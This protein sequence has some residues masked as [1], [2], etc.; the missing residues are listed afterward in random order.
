MRGVCKKKALT[1]KICLKGVVRSSAVC[2]QKCSDDDDGDGDAD[3]MISKFTFFNLK[4]LKTGNKS[5]FVLEI[6]KSYVSRLF[7]THNA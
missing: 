4:P 2:G 7:Y 6:K 5:P 1:T 3:A